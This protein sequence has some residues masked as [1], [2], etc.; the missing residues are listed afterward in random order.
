MKISEASIHLA[1]ETKKA[2]K[3]KEPASDAQKLEY[4]AKELEGLFLGQVIKAMRSTI[5]KES[6]QSTTMVDMMF[7]SVMGKCMADQ[8]GIGLAKFFFN[9][10]SEKDTEAIERLKNAENKVNSLNLNI[11]KIGGG[12]E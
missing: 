3:E 4:S 10:L 6:G 12:Y 7:S 9:A 11:N 5:P 2:Q 1:Q 8:G